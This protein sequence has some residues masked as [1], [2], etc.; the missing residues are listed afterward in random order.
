MSFE[1]VD[2]RR[3]EIQSMRLNAQSAAKLPGLRPGRYLLHSGDAAMRWRG[4]LEPS[5][6]PRRR[7][8]IGGEVVVK[9][10]RNE[11][12]LRLDGLRAR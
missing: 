10:G 2:E 7:R 11:L 5:C 12:A 1:Q 9:S 6:A 8:T 4:T 3:L